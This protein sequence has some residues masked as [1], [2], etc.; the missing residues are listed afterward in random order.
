MTKRRH[1]SPARN[2]RS[3]VP[4]E[5]LLEFQPGDGWGPL[6]EFLGQEIPPDNQP[7]P[8]LFETKDNRRWFLV[9]AAMGA[10][11]WL[12]GISAC[13]AVVYFGM[14]WLKSKLGGGPGEVEL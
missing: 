10:G 13:V 8:R 2:V 3:L 4:P 9:G 6:C 7:Y 5:K 11:I 12:A 14:P 1:G